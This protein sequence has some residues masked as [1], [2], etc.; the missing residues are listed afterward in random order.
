MA[1]LLSVSWHMNQRDLQV[2][3]LGASQVLGGNKWRS[4]LLRAFDFWKRDFDESVVHPSP[5]SAFSPA[6]RQQYSTEEDVFFECRT[7]FHH[8]AHMASHV[9]IV[10][11]QI[12]AG[13]GRLLGRSITL[14]DY[15]AARDKM[16]QRWA[17]R[18]SARDAAFYAL[19]FLSQVLLPDDYS[20]GNWGKNAPYVEY[21]ARD[22]QLFNRPWVLYYATLVVWCYGYALDGPI[23]PPPA[24][25]KTHAEQQRDMFV[26]LDR[27]GG[28]RTPN[29]LEAI[30]GRNRCLGLL[31][32]LKRAFANTRWEL[33]V[34]ASNLLRSCINMLKGIPPPAAAVGTPAG[35]PV[36]A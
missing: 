18:A 16:T 34:E 35:I 26:F 19:K 32:V 20:S 8:L 30:P 13:A 36:G 5:S 1:G 22:D 23:T 28:V 9:D 2:S 3:S 21:A 24:E 15:S 12:F 6:Y 25:L 7:V 33:L 11:C 29:D 31:L 14:R 17:T 27:V 10:D 4:A